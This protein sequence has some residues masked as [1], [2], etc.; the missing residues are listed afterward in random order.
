MNLNIFGGKFLQILYFPY[1]HHPF[2]IKNMNDYTYIEFY[3][4]IDDSVCPIY[5]KEISD[6][7]ESN[8]NK[9]VIFDF[10]EV[11]FIDSAG[12]GLI[13]GIIMFFFIVL[14]FIF[15]FSLMIICGGNSTLFS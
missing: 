14:Q 4:D 10:K 5:K 8:R 15:L 11:T 2:C 9:D 12:I 13:L 7:I 3:G 1:Y 6:L